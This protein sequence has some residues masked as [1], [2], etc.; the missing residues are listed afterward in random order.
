MN[1][2]VSNTSSCITFS[3]GGYGYLHVNYD[4]GEMF[5][6]FI[7]ELKLRPYTGVD[8]AYFFSEEVPVINP[9]IKG[10]WEM[11]LKDSLLHLIKLLK[12][13]LML[14]I[15]FE[16]K[17]KLRE[18]SLDRRGLYWTF[19]EH[20]FTM[21]TYIWYIMEMG[22]HDSCWY[23]LKCLRWETNGLFS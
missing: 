10:Y 16:G 6:D 15:W 19:Q 22:L 11:M 17:E 3:C 4:A 20:I 12:N 9:V 23:V 18:T 13:W 21:H 1:I 2:L 14:S 7:L 8:L 5:L